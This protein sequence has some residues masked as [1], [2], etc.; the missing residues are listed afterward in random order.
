[1]LGVT[2]ILLVS[3]V[4]FLECP[5]SL[6]MIVL[7]ISGSL[8]LCFVDHGLGKV[9]SSHRA[10]CFSSS[11]VTTCPGL[12]LLL[13]IENLP[14]MSLEYGAYVGCGLVLDFKLLSIEDGVHVG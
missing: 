8:H 4:S 5:K 14:V 1:M 11:A 7:L 9:I 2:K 3:L 13:A 10:A 6:A 12:V